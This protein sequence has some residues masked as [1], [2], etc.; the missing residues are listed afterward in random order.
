MHEI[1]GTDQ[2][3]GSCFNVS[4]TSQYKSI[5]KFRTEKNNNINDHNHNHNRPN[6]LYLRNFTSIY[7]Y[8][9]GATGSIDW[10]NHILMADFP[11]S[12]RIFY[13]HNDHKQRSLIQKWTSNYVFYVNIAYGHIEVKYNHRNARHKLH[14]YY[15]INILFSLNENRNNF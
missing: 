1:K 13:M 6:W 4:V 11:K 14:Y 9:L 3:C 10:L 15:F 7:H 12:C 2:R 8:G 5:K